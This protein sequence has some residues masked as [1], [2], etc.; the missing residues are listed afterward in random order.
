MP[1]TEGQNIIELGFNV[2]EFSAE[3][4][5]VLDMLID[6]FDQLKKYDG[7]KFNPLG[8]G[9]L[10][11]LKKSLQEGQAALQEFL[12]KAN[13]YNRIITEQFE[14]DRAAKKAKDDLSAAEKIHAKNLADTLQVK[15]KIGEVDTNAARELAEQKAKYADLNKEV[16]ANAKAYATQAGSVGE[17]RAA[18]ALLT[19]QRD[20]ENA[21]TEEGKAKI[22]ELNS[23][24]DKQ[25]EFIRQNSSLLEKQKINI[26]NYTG[27]AAVLRESLDGI[28]S[29]LDSFGKSGD[30]ASEAYQHLI[31][32]Q[33]LLQAALDKQEAGF[34]GVTQEIR[35]MKIV[36]DTLTV[37]GFEHTEAFE[38]LNA[39]YTTSKQ[40][41]TELHEEQKILTSEEPGFTALA[42]AARGL[43]GA[44]AIGAGA[45][46]LFAS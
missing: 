24:I 3:K 2:E 16:A 5:Q 17:A 38:K 33:R 4:K 41:L 12:G 26:G 42:A 35:Q 13:D 28:N 46:A 1:N 21:T 10:A 40:K 44:Y 29:K 9:G 45:S 15:A 37:A 30:T 18:V 31:L 22:L 43:G 20:R 27:A 8:N 19:I 25:N 36:L 11:D 39:V 14:K 7:T 6:L 34:G 23:L 32:E